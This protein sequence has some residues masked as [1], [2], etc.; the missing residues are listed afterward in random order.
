MPPHSP[1]EASPI[2]RLIIS[3][4]PIHRT[5][6][7]GKEL[8]NRNP[9]VLGRNPSTIRV[10][11]GAS[12]RAP[13]VASGSP[14]GKREPAPLVLKNAITGRPSGRIVAVVG[15]GRVG[16]PEGKLRVVV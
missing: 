13:S 4:L 8:A 6:T 12:L 9:D 10:A 2:P 11:M 3:G 1:F 15:L 7:W 16:D 14:P 5:G